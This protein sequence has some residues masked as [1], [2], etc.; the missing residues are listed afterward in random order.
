MNLQLPGESRV[1]E[2]STQSALPS[3]SSDSAT[4]DCPAAELDPARTLVTVIDPQIGFS[5]LSGTLGRAFGTDELSTIR[6]ALDQLARF[7]A[8][9]PSEVHVV[10]VT[11]E[12]AR[13]QH[14]AGDLSDPLSGLCVSGLGRDCELADG[15]V[16][17]K[18]WT[19]ALKL[20]SDAWSSHGFRA[21]VGQFILEG[22]QTLLVA[23]LTATTCVLQ[24]I[25]SL[26]RSAD[27]R[28]VTVIAVRD[29]I[30][31]RASTYRHDRGMSRVDRAYGQMDA[32]GAVILPSWRSIY[33]RR[34]HT[35]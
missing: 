2:T 3:S 5:S 13:G 35:Q 12:Y 25:L 1:T 21:A 30:G 22:G 20:R 17:N 24:T 29:L 27:R 14:T 6:P 23:G 10:L 32:A 9:I 34:R 31:A 16:P 11:S 19:I 26:L 18:S 28:D 8:S 15:I 33:W 7:L 4:A